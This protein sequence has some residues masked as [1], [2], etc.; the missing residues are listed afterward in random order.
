MNEETIKMYPNLAENILNLTS[1]LSSESAVTINNI[2]G[3]LIDQY[4]FINSSTINVE[5]YPKGWYVV[6]ISNNTAIHTQRV[7]IK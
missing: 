2:Q 5:N 1:N 4:S 6:T 3:V 7:L